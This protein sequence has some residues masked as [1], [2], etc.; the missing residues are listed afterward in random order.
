MRISESLAPEAR[1]LPC[2]RINIKDISKDSPPISER[3]KEETTF[4]KHSLPYHSSSLD[5]RRECVHS[6]KPHRALTRS[7]RTQYL[8][9]IEVQGPDGPCVFLSLGNQGLLS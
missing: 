9:R 8:E 3:K 6:D 7:T 1:R 4:G 2:I 5:A